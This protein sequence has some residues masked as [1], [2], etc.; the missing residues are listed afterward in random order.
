MGAGPPTAIVVTGFDPFVSGDTQ[1]RYT[2]GSFGE[3][4]SIENRTDPNTGSALGICWIKYRDNAR[5]GRLAAD[6]AKRAEGGAT[7]IRVGTRTVTVER[8]RSGKKANRYVERAARKAEERRRREMEAEEAKRI[9]KMPTSQ[10]AVNGGGDASP[11][12]PPNAPKG[13]SGKSAARPPEAPRAAAVKQAAQELVEQEPV[14]GTI[15]RKPYIFIPDSSVPVMGT[16]ISHLKKRMKAYD[17]REVRCDQKGYYMIFENSKRGEEEAVRCHTDMNGKPMFT[18]TLQMECQ[19]YGNP[20]YERSPSPERAAMIKREQEDRERRE[21]DTKEDWEA[22]RKVRAEHLD[23]AAAA[24][25]QLCSELLDFVTGDL[26]TKIAASVFHDFLEPSRHAAKREELGI[27]APPERPQNQPLFIAGD[28]AGQSRSNSRLGDPRRQ[29]F[30]GRGSRTS[31]NAFVDERRQKASKRRP[32]AA[33]SLH[34][35]LARMQEEESDEEEKASSRD[36]VKDH[37]SRSI[38]RFSSTAPDPDVTSRS[39]LRAIEG[40]EL[41]QGEESGEDDMAFARKFLDPNLLRKEPEDMALAELQQVVS[42][43]PRTSNL[44]KHAQ[45]ELRIRRRNRDDDRLFSGIKNE[46]VAQSVEVSVEDIGL[47]TPEEELAPVKSKKAGKGKKKSKKQ[48]FQE[49]EAAK[50]AAQSAKALLKEESAP[51]PEA[52]AIE[53]GPVKEEY[54]EDEEERAEV[55]WGV[56][57]DVPRRTVEDEPDLV[58]D[59]DG[60]QH[61]VKDDE[62]FGFL[63]DALTSVT[64]AKLGSAHT[65]AHN[66]KE[67]KRLNIDSD[68]PNSDSAIIRGYYVPNESGS[69]RTEGVAKILESEKSKYLP[70]RLKVAAARAQRQAEKT[71]P[72]AAVNAEA[73]KKAKLA[74][75]AASRS[76]RATNRTAMKDINTVKQNLI[77]DGQQGDAVRFNALKKRK[78]LVKFERSAIHG[79][80]LYAD[81]NIALGDMIIEYV[82]EKV[83][84][85]VANIRE[86][87]YDKQGMG[88]SYLFR[89]DDDSVVDATKKGGIARFINHSCAPNCTAKIIKV[90]GT[91]RIV[92]YA[93]KEIAKGEM[94]DPWF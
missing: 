9:A 24:H 75:T 11:A 34:N 4:A 7:S 64:P 49:R 37:D 46:D 58:M 29:A 65:W 12:P 52:Q 67:I 80:G 93:L 22:E 13:P 31:G 44:H 3:I 70:H 90:E 55:E 81:E 78:K 40:E 92:I 15:K 33:L 35:L 50:A 83:R 54:E 8:D 94:C 60:W 16:T 1:L 89:I 45:K 47:M 85:A 71:N 61:V 32:A 18:Y 6:A 19:Q 25:E 86:I 69:A 23:T 62:D 87:R 43:L 5:E 51:T 20:D 53:E 76:N 91:K 48:A 88:S 84:Q 26:K 59:I 30:A 77:L 38:S 28:V 66:Q 56:S 41:L 73:A 10:A 21:Q 72:P 14:L 17:W 2:F 63:Q 42:T 74:S 27:S 39:R 36:E 79:W 68:D 82:G 57:T